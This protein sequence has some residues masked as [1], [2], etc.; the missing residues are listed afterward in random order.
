MLCFNI[1][2]SYDVKFTLSWHC[3]TVIVWY[4]TLTSRLALGISLTASTER[5]AGYMC[6]I[7]VK[8]TS[9]ISGRSLKCVCASRKV[10]YRHLFSFRHTRYLKFRST[11]RSN[12]YMFTMLIAPINSIAKH[13]F[14]IEVS[15]NFAM[16]CL[17]FKCSN[18]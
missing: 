5:L 11:E 13:A 17:V 10:S 4:K 7:W 16:P 6:T 1:F 3:S 8:S 2:N 14:D 12:N 18:I 9:Q 15:F